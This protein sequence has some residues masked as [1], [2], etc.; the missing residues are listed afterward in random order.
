MHWSTTS[1]KVNGVPNVE[2][3]KTKIAGIKKE[4]LK[5]EAS[6]PLINEIIVNNFFYLILSIYIFLLGTTLAIKMD[7]YKTFT[8]PNLAS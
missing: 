5:H 8:N 4:A 2:N 6:K 7:F 1:L 3:T